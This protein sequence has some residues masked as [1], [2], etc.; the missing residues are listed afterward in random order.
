MSPFKA[1]DPVIYTTQSGAR[2]YYATVQDALL[3]GKNRIGGAITPGHRIEI[4]D[5]TRTY[6]D[7]MRARH[8]GWN[9]NEP[10]A[11]YRFRKVADSSL[12]HDR[13]PRR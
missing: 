13:E 9:S 1:G 8:P 2:E 10:K 5:F 11:K 12:R 7:Q 3:V 6:R 4:H